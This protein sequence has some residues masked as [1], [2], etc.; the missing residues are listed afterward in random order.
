MD[1]GAE[2]AYRPIEAEGASLKAAA[3][4]SKGIQRTHILIAF[5]AQRVAVIDWRQSLRV[6]IRGSISGAKSAPVARAGSTARSGYVV[7]REDPR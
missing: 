1:A 3:D 6:F 2:F 7:R 5:T 4:P